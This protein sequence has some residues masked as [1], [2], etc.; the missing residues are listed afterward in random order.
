M[1]IAGTEYNLNHRALEIYISG[2]KGPYC[3]GCHNTDLWDFNL[4][5]D[6]LEY[7]EELYDSATREMVDSIWILGGEPQDQ[8]LD[9]LNG[10]LKMCRSTKKQIVLF[11]RF[12]KLL[13]GV[14]ERNI[15]YIKYG[16]YDYLGEPYVESILGV[17]LASRNQYIKKVNAE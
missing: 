6:F 2:C 8:N 3:A 15:D 7:A 4:G 10:L 9:E 14:D 11:T 1:K 17:K 12:T 16:P 13:S 5:W